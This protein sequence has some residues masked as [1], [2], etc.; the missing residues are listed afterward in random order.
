MPCPAHRSTPR[1]Q[2]GSPLLHEPRPC[3]HPSSVA[4]AHARQGPHGS[5]HQ[6]RPLRVQK[7]HQQGHAVVLEDPFGPRFLTAEDNEVVGGLKVQRKQ[8]RSGGKSGY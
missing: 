2:A 5:Q 6:L 8:Q 4:T 1:P 3:P 7:L